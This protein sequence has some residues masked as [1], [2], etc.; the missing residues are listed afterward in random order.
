MSLVDR[1]PS[2]S[3]A[4]NF[5]S[6][7]DQITRWSWKEALGSLRPPK[8]RGEI[9]KTAEVVQKTIARSAIF[10]IKKGLHKKQDWFWDLK[11]RTKVFCAGNQSGKT[12][13]LLVELASCILGCR[14]YDMENPPLV[15][16]N[17]LLLVIAGPD[18][19]TWAS[20]NI[21]PKLEQLLPLDALVEHKSRVQGGAIDYMRFWNGNQLKVM[22]YEQ[23]DFKFESWTV[24]GFFWDE[25]MP[26]GKYIGAQRG[27]MAKMAP[28]V[29]AYTPRKEAWTLDAF[30]EP[31]FH[32]NTK[33]EYEEALDRQRRGEPY[34]IISIETTSYDNPYIAE[35]EIRR[36]E[37][38]LPE[39]ERES[40]ILGKYKALVGLV[41]KSFSYELHVAELPFQ[42][43]EEWALFDQWPKFMVVDPHDAKPFACIWGVVTPRGHYHIF[44]EW[45]ESNYWNTPNPKFGCDRYLSL[46]RQIEAGDNYIERP[47]ENMLFFIM[48]PNFG[49]APQTGP[50]T[51]GRTMQMEFSDLGRDFD[52]SVDDDVSSGHLMVRSRLADPPRLFLTPNCQNLIHSFRR[53]NYDEYRQQ[54]SF[55]R[56]KEAPRE[57][58]KD[59]MDTVRYLCK[60]EVTF[61]ERRDDYGGYQE[62]PG[63]GY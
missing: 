7:I 44:Q 22:T 32:V 30:Y 36:F 9:Q 4:E 59:F 12:I 53:Y 43:D 2:H 26:Q 16:G 50:K 46:F 62:T 14:P 6:L 57:E 56:V 61:I 37:E 40:R 20:L 19:S 34:P 13:A 39:E 3:P 1:L 42:T 45:P 54:Q 35:E 23:D 10:H 29:L 15:E 33:A 60:S 41:Y 63:L 17:D 18:F 55:L 27:S 24:D 49:R 25:P 5:Q 28:H 51:G 47:L 21:L 48:D 38:S 11:P 8:S 31:A 52:C 58:Y